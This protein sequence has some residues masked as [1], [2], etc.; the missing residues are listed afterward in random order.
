[1]RSFYGHNQTYVVQCSNE[2]FCFLK[3]NSA[4]RQP[5]FQFP[6]ILLFLLGWQLDRLVF[7]RPQKAYVGKRCSEWEMFVCCP[8]PP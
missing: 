4:T 5:S 3:R 7:Q 2:G 8:W 6:E 1:M